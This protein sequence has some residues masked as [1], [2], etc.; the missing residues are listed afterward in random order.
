MATSRWD[1]VI[2]MRPLLPL[3]V[4]WAYGVCD[5]RE[6]PWAPAAGS[7]GRW[8]AE[9]KA[10]VL[11]LELSKAG[12]RWARGNGDKAKRPS[13]PLHPERVSRAERMHEGSES[14]EGQGAG[15]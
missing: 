6:R 13:F 8:R 7:S 4:P 11:P 15:S 5:A 9:L 12:V 10:G 2:A 3:T 1:E 14:P